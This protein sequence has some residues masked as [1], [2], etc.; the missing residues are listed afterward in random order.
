MI[1]E[2]R[3]KQTKMVVLFAFSLLPLVQYLLIETLD[4]SFFLS[5][6]S[7]LSWKHGKGSVLSGEILVL[8]T[9]LTHLVCPRALLFLFRSNDSCAEF[10]P[11]F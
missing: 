6:Y 10:L 7:S 5:R 1:K 4:E 9:S 11:R 8:L 2:L 3:W